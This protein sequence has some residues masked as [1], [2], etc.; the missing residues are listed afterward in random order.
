MSAQRAVRIAYLATQSGSTGCED[1][2][3]DV[4]HNKNCA[5][6]LNSVLHCDEV[7]A[8]CLHST[9]MPVCKGRGDRR[10]HRDQVTT[11]PVFEVFARQ[12]SMDPGSFLLHRKDPDSL[13]D[14]FHSHDLVSKHGA[15]Q[16]IPCRLFAD[17]A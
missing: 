2:A 11:I 9:T 8:E 13:C 5:R 4:K 12:F 17:F 1:F 6:L 15:D 14:N 10:A 7:R 16:G 3:R